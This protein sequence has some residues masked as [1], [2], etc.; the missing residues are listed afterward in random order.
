MQFEKTV[1]EQVD[2]LVSDGTVE[3]IIKSQLE[4]TITSVVNDLMRD[5]SDF[6]KQLKQAISAALKIDLSQLSMLE[7]NH[8]VTTVVK[9][10]LDKTL[11]S[12][13]KEPIA[14]AIHGYTGELEK[15]EWKLSEIIEK[16]IEHV[17]DE[18]SSEEYGEIT[19]IVKQSYGSTHVYFDKDEDKENYHCE[20]QLDFNKQGECYSFQ[21]K[22]Y[23]THKGDLRGAPIF[24][25]FDKFLFKIYAMGCTIINDERYCQREWSRY[26]N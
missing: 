23:R 5:Y 3:A 15:K 9:E 13:V 20:Y 21:V 6:G 1:Q 7:Y 8:I 25:S 16:F 14:K 26:D 17:M 2:K 24:G 11:L 22:D 18:K 4:K 12:H 19:L 10:E